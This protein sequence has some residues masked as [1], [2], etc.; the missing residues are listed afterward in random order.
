MHNKRLQLARA[1]H[2]HI[3]INVLPVRHISQRGLSLIW[4]VGR[5]GGEVGADQIL[6]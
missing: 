2:W 6:G 4:G 5:V 1:S 3:V